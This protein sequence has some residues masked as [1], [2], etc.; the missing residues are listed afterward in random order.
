MILMLR[1]YRAVELTIQVFARKASLRSARRVC[2][3]S[4]HRRRIQITVTP[5]SSPYATITNTNK[6]TTYLRLN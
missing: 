5:Y 6:Q 4:V 3:R 1:R 2:V